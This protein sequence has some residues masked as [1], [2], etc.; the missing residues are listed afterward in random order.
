MLKIPLG[1]TDDIFKSPFCDIGH[2][3][4]ENVNVSTETK[5]EKDPD[6]KRVTLEGMDELW[7]V[8]TTNISPDY[9]DKEKAVKLAK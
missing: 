8:I 2:R 1:V 6:V 4:L 7:K 5:V 3:P 9:S